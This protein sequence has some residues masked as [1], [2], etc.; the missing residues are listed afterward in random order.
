MSL[1][2]TPAGFAWTP[3]T[4]GA[5]LTCVPLGGAAR[6]LFTTRQLLLRGG[7]ETQPEAWNAL[8]AAVDAPP[9]RLMRVRQ[10]HGRVVRVL[11]R[12]EVRQ[13]A[14][15][16]LEP[17]DATRDLYLDRPDADAIVSNI[18]GLVLCVLVADCVPVLLVDPRSGA[19]AAI[20]A[21]WRGT[22]AGI[23]EAAVTAMTREL[24]AAPQ[25]IIAAIGPSIRPCCY[26]VGEELVSAFE[27]A[28]HTASDIARWFSRVP[29][30][31][32]TGTSL[33]L[34]VAGSNRDQLV[35]AGLR[36]ENIFDCGF[37]TK[38]HRETF[39]SYRADGE[40]AGR[41]AAIVVVPPGA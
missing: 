10:V 19:A 26:E 22:C 37:C 31:E 15:P 41:M 23:V 6:H 33:R 25:R 40:Q 35:A 11:G 1:P 32:G 39:D 12:R 29:A 4:W 9:D 34:D 28:G 18:P 16:T 3:A 2:L 17:A 30:D 14:N 5:A 24:G 38:T 20:H 13:T 21:G 36:V 7:P 8:V 27:A